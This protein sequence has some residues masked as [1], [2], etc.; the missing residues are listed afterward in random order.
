MVDVRGDSESVKPPVKIAVTFAGQGAQ[1]PGMGKD[2][3][4]GSPAARTIFDAAGAELTEIIFNGTAEQLK[5]T[6]VTQPAVYTVD[7][8]AWAAFTE[9]CSAAPDDGLGDDGPVIEIIGTAGFSLGEYAAL[10]AAGVIPSF[11]TGLELV[12]KRALLMAEAGRHAD[13]SP[14]GAMAAVLGARADVIEV[15][16]AS[17]GDHVLEAVNF[18]SPAQTAIAGDAE[19]IAAFSKNA[20]ES[21]RK[22]RAIPLAVSSAFHS[23]IMEPAAAGIGEAASAISFGEPGYEV[24]LNLTGKPLSE[25]AGTVNEIM[26]Q[27]VK[28]PVFWQETLE[29]LAEAGAQTVLELGPGKTLTGLA[30]KTIPDTRA[31]QAEDIQ[32]IRDALDAIRGII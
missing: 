24:Y 12:R 29:N 1:Y 5:D 13:G 10:T 25:Y 22:L 32:G 2:L 19:G 4:D 31:L 16:A 17:Q 28:S 9:A 26:M 27:Q 6:R 14:R 11:E 18:N 15:V 23:S 3:Y 20:K 8:A 30:K 7:M 21:G